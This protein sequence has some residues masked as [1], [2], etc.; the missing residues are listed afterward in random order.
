MRSTGDYVLLRLKE[1]ADEG[2][3]DA[4]V[5]ELRQVI[6]SPYLSISD[7]LGLARMCDDINLQDHR[8]ATL[9]VAYQRFPETD[10]VLLALVDAYDD[11]PVPAIQE[12]GRIMLEKFLG[13]ERSTDGTLKIA[14]T[15]GPPNISAFG[16]LFNLYFT[17]NRQDWIL[18]L[19]DA[20]L[21]AAP[22]EVLFLRNRARALAE[23]GDSRADQAFSELVEKNSSDSTVWGWYASH[24]TRQKRF[25]EAYEA[26]EMAIVNNP[27]EPITYI[28]L[29]I[30]ILNENLVRQA[31]GE[32]STVSRDAALH[33]VV[34][35]MTA[36]IEN[37][38]IATRQLVVNMLVRRG[39]L[40]EA[41]SF[42]QSEVPQGRYDNEPLAYVRRLIA[43][44][45]GSEE[46]VTNEEL[47]TPG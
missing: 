16:I 25:V 1:V 23:L 20:V 45:Q 43:E 8:R 29:A 36:A 19:C 42:A 10:S 18:Q 21:E 7:L 13:I 35:L 47:L 24:L 38:T 37:G 44:K 2:G 28:N 9:E 3:R 17:A 41:R 26:S 4:F 30:E 22:N 34:P 39:A 40:R 6:K 31:N 32:I 33:A 14:D 11:S 12:R 5:A 15:G 46:D 27:E